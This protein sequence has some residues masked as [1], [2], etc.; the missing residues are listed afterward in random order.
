MFNSTIY[1]TMPEAILNSLSKLKNAIDDGQGTQYEKVVSELEG[2][3]VHLKN[4]LYAFDESTI[5][6]ITD[7]KGKIIYANKSFCHISKYK[8]EELLGRNHN[9]LKSGYHDSVFYKNIW[10]TILSGN[11][12]RG[13]IKN[14]A[15]D[16]SMYWVQTTIVPIFNNE[17]QI[18]YF[19]SF[20]TDITR[21]KQLELLRIEEIKADF[22]Q[23]VQLINNAVFKLC[24]DKDGTIYYD[25][26]EGQLATQYNVELKTDE[27]NTPQSLF[28]P[29]EAEFMLAQYKIA[30]NGQSHSYKHT[31]FGKWVY[32]VL[33]PIMEDDQVIA[34]IG[35]VSDFTEMEKAQQTIEFL[36]YHD[37]LTNLPN[38]RSFLQA[39]ENTQKQTFAVIHID[40]DRF[41]QINETFG[42][43]VGDDVIIHISH[44]LRGLHPNSVYRLSGD[45][46]VIIVDDCSLE[47][48]LNKYCADILT[49]L[50]QPFLVG[51]HELLIT[52]SIGA[53]IYPNKTDDIS[54]I[55]KHCDIAM[56]RSKLLGRHSYT[57]FSQEIYSSYNDK[58]ILESELR[59]AIQDGNLTLQYQP[60]LD[61]SRNKTVG[62]EA[63]VRWN[64]PKHGMIA[65]DT[66]IPVAE[67]TGLI[68]PLGSWV[69][70]EACRQMVKWIHDGYNPIRIAVN[71]SAIE[72][73]RP[74][75]VE[76][77]KQIL[78]ETGLPAKYLELELTE[79]TIMHANDSVILNELR[80]L[81]VYLSI[82][83]F[84]TGYSSLSY[85]K[86]FPIH[87]LKIDRSFVQDLH[88]NNSSDAEIIRA[89]I[90]L[91]HT[92]GLVVIAEGVEDE[93][94]ADFLNKNNCD[95]LQG[96]YYSK[97]I[98]AEDVI[99]FFE[100]TDTLT[101]SY[102]K[103]K[104]ELDESEQRYRSLFDYNPNPSFILNL[105]G[106]F[107]AVNKAAVGLTGFSKS[108]LE[109]KDFTA[110]VAAD[111][112]ETAKEHFQQVL[113]QNSVTFELR[114]TRKDGKIL[115]THITA[116]P[117]VVD[118]DVVGVIGIAQDTTLQKEFLLK[119]NRDLQLA[120]IVQESVSPKSLINEVC[121]IQAVNLPSAELSG[122]IYSWYQID[123][124]RYGVMLLDI[125]GHGLS[126]SLVAMSIKSLLEGLI[127]KVSDPEGI[128]NELNKHVFRLFKESQHPV[129]TFCTAIY[130]LLDTSTKTI[131]YFNAG[132]PHGL[133]IKKDK[134]Y[135]EL[136]HGGIPIGL[137]PTTS[138]SVGNV[139]YEPD[140]YI[141][142]YTDGLLEIFENSMTLCSDWLVDRITH[143]KDEQNIMQ[144]LQEEVQL[145][146]KRSDDLSLIVIELPE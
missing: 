78:T 108:D 43:Q 65:P 11:I 60:K 36:A 96:Y 59:K 100:K 124:N 98:A 106:S 37:D 136:A 2:F 112:V 137:L 22:L 99:S 44:I 21:E 104:R 114:I 93:R 115:Y 144:K 56:Q 103:V 71:I 66:F 128:Y 134:T 133:L 76:K 81:G 122:D 34:V 135:E 40:I 35:S 5:I 89:I 31:L 55:L 116:V 46:F 26:L 125:M 74:N 110:I 123:Q 49:A 57:I 82:D 42:H 86:S 29:K 73:Q 13:Q 63:L 6:A 91:A 121:T 126:S 69:L 146:H 140:S 64:S 145:L 38:R 129:T 9:I 18:D 67:E 58:L 41:K 15:K 83:D 79:N 107:T 48:R 92:F 101:S 105:K 139:N 4:L 50:Q 10:N 1:E 23:T 90:Q 12:W 52:C 119:R 61:I 77:V 85:L 3:I 20:R 138:L 39:I 16:G 95:Q 7:V 97:P 80:D 30:F 62:V 88:S 53:T 54:N 33:T 111:D 51:E 70:R 131:E 72:L 118:E 87:T 102:D 143:Y 113:A 8:K 84:G 68:I 32:T 142:L 27:R 117:M 75:F 127:T 19:I 17:K 94:M 130:L 25:L 141:I 47:D 109:Q 45:E 28:T 14:R 120:R 24:R 132:H